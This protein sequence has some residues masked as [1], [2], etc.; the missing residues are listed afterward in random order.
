ML[1][2]AALGMVKVVSMCSP[3]QPLEDEGKEK[4]PRQRRWNKS[5]IHVMCNEMEEGMYP[6]PSGGRGGEPG[7]PG[8]AGGVFWPGVSCG[9]WCLV[10]EGTRREQRGP[11]FVL[12]PVAG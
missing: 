10:S 3:P 1:T 12:V 5:Y 9:G 6:P 7:A 2:T 4:D 11:P 8:L